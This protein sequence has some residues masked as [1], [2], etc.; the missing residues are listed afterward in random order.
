MLPKRLS[1]KTQ[2]QTN[3]RQLN[4]EESISTKQKIKKKRTFLLIVLTLTIGLSIIFS[5]YRLTAGLSSKLHFS[6]PKININFPVSQKSIKI[7]LDKPIKSLLSSPDSWSIYVKTLYSPW[8]SWSL[9]S[10]RSDIDGV[11][12]QLSSQP[13]DTSTLVQD[14]LPQGSLVQ[15]N[16]ISQDSY[17]EYQTIIS[18]PGQQI[19]ILINGPD[20]KLI[21]LLIQTIYWQTVH[22]S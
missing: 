10:H 11:I 3:L 2:Q 18:V 15:E 22:P 9:N 7:N 13:P 4:L 16:L 14:H 8:L 20:K 5:L 19:F 21:P 12:N 1:K 17:F 6:F